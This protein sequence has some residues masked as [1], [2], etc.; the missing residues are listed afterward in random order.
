[1]PRRTGDYLR[2]ACPRCGGDLRAEPVEYGVEWVCVNLCGARL[3]E[4]QVNKVIKDKE[5]RLVAEAAAQRKFEVTDGVSKE[6]D[7]KVD[8]E[9]APLVDTRS[10]ARKCYRCEF[11]GKD[12]AETWCMSKRCPSHYPHRL[13]PPYHSPGY[14]TGSASELDEKEKDEIIAYARI[15]GSKAAGKRF[16]IPWTRV[17]TLCGARTRLDKDVRRGSKADNRKLDMEELPPWNEAWGDSVKVA[18]LETLR[19]IQRKD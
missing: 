4:V 11:F 16:K 6:T 3:T 1:M 7:E 5:D 8:Q 12:G 9:P 13:R 2:G 19:L 14:K 15:H 17:R 10:R 18:W